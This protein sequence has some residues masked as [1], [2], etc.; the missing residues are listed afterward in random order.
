MQYAPHLLHTLSVGCFMDK[1]VPH[2]SLTKF[3]KL[4]KRRKCTFLISRFKNKQNVKA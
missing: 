1:Y 2:I 4:N 3:N